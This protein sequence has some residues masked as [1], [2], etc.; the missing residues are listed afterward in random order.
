[1]PRTSTLNSKAKR[2]HTRRTSAAWLT[3]CLLG[4]TAGCELIPREPS[5]RPSRETT[6]EPPAEQ[7][8]PAEAPAAE[9]S[10]PEAGGELTP[11]EAEE[12]GRL[13]ARAERAIAADHLTY[14]AKGSALA[15]Y[16][17]VRILDPDN[18]EARRGEERIV[19][20]YLEL[21]LEAADRR[22]F[23]AARAM[24]DRARLVD[25]KHPGIT[26]AAYRVQMLA[27]AERRVISLDGQRLRDQD[28]ELAET[29]RRAGVVSRGNGC[30]AQ[31]IAP[32]DSSGRWIYQ[33]MSGAPGASR[34]TA[35][36]E[37]G[38]PPRVE[39]LCF[40]ESP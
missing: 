31:I 20:R 2:P 15:L 9:T 14:P 18:D 30:R 23:S 22:R 34:I 8:D 32:N 5:D 10:A 1:M 37:I 21:A 3:V 33:Q 40:P 19:E 27:K 39:V 28:P 38:S 26:P 16:D 29:L 17:R 24:L 36:L 7:P 4:F 11:G 25:P 6:A 13:L 35:E 12:V